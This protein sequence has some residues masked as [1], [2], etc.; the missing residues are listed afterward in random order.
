MA[1]PDSPARLEEKQTD[2]IGRR[3]EQN[4]RDQYTQDNELGTNAATVAVLS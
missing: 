2:D 4:D 3:D 1:I